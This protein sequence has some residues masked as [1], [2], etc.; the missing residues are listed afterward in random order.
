MLEFSRNDTT[1]VLLLEGEQRG[2]TRQETNCGRFRDSSTNMGIFTSFAVTQ[3]T[4]EL[5]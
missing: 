2:G 1:A 4:V 3:Y 5:K